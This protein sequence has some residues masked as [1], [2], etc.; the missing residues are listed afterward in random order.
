MPTELTYGRAD[1]CVDR[2]EWGTESVTGARYV[3]SSEKSVK[4]S[5]QHVGSDIPPVKN[6]TTLGSRKSFIA[7]PTKAN[8]PAKLPILAD[9]GTWLVP[10]TLKDSSFLLCNKGGAR[11]GIHE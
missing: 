3:F 1:D 9:R 5:K 2:D 10:Q 11:H 4:G 6:V 7:M 8:I